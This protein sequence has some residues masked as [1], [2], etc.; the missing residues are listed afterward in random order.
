[1]PLCKFPEEAS[2][3]GSGNLYVASSWTCN[4][5]DTRMLTVGTAGATS[6]AGTA[7]ALQYLTDPIPEGLGGQ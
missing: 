3:L 1:M 2:Y 5:S 6:G 4:P 7:T